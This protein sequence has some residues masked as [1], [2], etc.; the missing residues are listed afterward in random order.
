MHNFLTID[1][2]RRY[3]KCRVLEG[4]TKTPLLGVAP[5]HL[6][7]GSRRTLGKSV[8]GGPCRDI[9]QAPELKVLK[10]LGGSC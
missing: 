7:V 9:K 4:V 2:C 8:E 1:N 5:R 10:V 6:G 3:E